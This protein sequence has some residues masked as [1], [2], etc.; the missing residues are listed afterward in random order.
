MDHRARLAPATL[1]LGGARA[2]KSRYAESLID[3]AGVPQAVYIATAQAGDLEM[4]TRIAAHRAQRDGKWLTVEE[5]LALADA[6]AAHA[7]PERPM[8]VD[9]LTL[10]L[11]NLLGA[12]EDPDEAC[13]QLLHVL[14][15][16]PCAVLMVSNEVGLGIVPDNA[17]A[18]EFRDHAGRLHQR[19]AAGVERVVFVAAGLPLLLKDRPVPRDWAA[20]RLQ[21]HPLAPSNADA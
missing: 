10:W 7:Q 8:L 14:Q 9:C 3:G 21:A 11:S 6:L 18:R 1:I 20:Q 15:R 16:L 2:G 4:A 19:I 13:D 5:P 12:G 17:L